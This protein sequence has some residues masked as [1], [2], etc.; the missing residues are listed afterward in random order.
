[1]K[2]ITGIYKKNQ[3]V[4]VS[5]FNH[6][7]N[8]KPPKILTTSSGISQKPFRFHSKSIF[9]V[10]TDTNYNQKISSFPQRFPFEK[11]NREYGR[12]ILEI[13]R[14]L[15]QSLPFQFGQTTNSEHDEY[16]ILKYIMN[17]NVSNQ[18]LF[19]A[20]C[21]DLAQRLYNLRSHLIHWRRTKKQMSYKSINH[22][23]NVAK[24]F[25]METSKQQQFEYYHF[26]KHFKVAQLNIDI[27]HEQFIAHKAKKQKERDQYGNI[28]DSLDS[29]YYE[30]SHKIS[31]RTKWFVAGVVTTISFI[32]WLVRNVDIDDDHQPH[33]TQ[34]R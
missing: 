34:K 32:V 8:A 10:E 13:I 30:Y 16:Y 15:L 31:T 3:I 2:N 6:I 12:E 29:A 26:R 22:Y 18:Y 20:K 27:L 28:R 17:T 7:F 21:I 25:I 19:S 9:Y 5:I 1:M 24:Q 11:T 23:M 33:S 4:Q 14:Y